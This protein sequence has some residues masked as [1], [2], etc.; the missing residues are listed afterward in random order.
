MVSA[1]KIKEAFA[2]IKN[3]IVVLQAEVAR[4]SK[5]NEMLIKI[6]K[7]QTDALVKSS[8]T[9]SKKAVKKTN[10]KT[11]FVASRNGGK[12]HRP[13]CPYAKNIKPKDRVKFSTKDAALNN[14]YK[15]CKCI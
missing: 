13:S 1:K 10:K 3:D 4:L 15:A 12:F 6:V 9:T 5:E 2:H 11:Q 7:K 14:G 8:K